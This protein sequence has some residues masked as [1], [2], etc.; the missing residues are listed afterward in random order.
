MDI[1]SWRCFGRRYREAAEKKAAQDRYA[2]LHAQGVSISQLLNPPA[3]LQA[4]L[5]RQRVISPDY[6]KSGD[7]ENKL[8]LRERPRQRVSCGAPLIYGA[9]V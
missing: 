2:K 8:P 1:V 3:H 7:V 9:D 4:R 6:K 5:Q